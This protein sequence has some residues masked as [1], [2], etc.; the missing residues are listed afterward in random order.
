MAPEKK[1]IR[2]DFAKAPFAQVYKAPVRREGEHH[3][4]SLTNAMPRNDIERDFAKPEIG[5]DGAIL[6]KPSMMDPKAIPDDIDGYRRDET[7]P[8]L[9]H[10]AWPPCVARCHGIKVKENGCID[11]TMAC[12]HPGAVTY[13]RPVDYA[14][15]RGCPLRT[16][17]PP[18]RPDSSV[19][20]PAKRDFKQPTIQPDGRLVYEKTGW[21]PPVCPDGYNRDP[22]NMWAFI[23]VWM[24]CADRDFENNVRPCGCITVNAVCHSETSGRK[25]KK[26]ASITC[27]SC[28]VRREPGSGPELFQLK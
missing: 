9:F 11:V 16:Q 1:T 13:G 20:I 27:Q 3:L 18:S 14:T 22:D 26:V 25:D 4:C 21:E 7:N 8:L 24:P 28:P 10:P 6:Y 19:P 5:K 23:P 12:N 2:F 17:K 15:C